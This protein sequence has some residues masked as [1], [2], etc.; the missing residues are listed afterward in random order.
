LIAV[1]G[2]SDGHRAP[3]VSVIIVTF[4]SVS[5]I[6]ACLASLEASSDVRLEVIVVDNAS[7]DETTAV[8][9]ACGPRVIVVEAGANLGFAQACN[10]GAT[11]ATAPLL[12]FLNPDTVVE[13]EAIAAAAEALW[14]DPS[15]GVVGAMTLYENGSLNPTCCF[16]QP[17]LTGTALRAIGLSTVRKGSSRLNPEEM[18]GWDRST[19]RDVGVVTGCFFLIERELFRHLRGF[20]ERFFMYSE[21]TDLSLRVQQVG[22]RCVHLATARVIHH[23]GRSDTVAAHKM[24]KTFR[25]RADF[26][27]KHWHPGKAVVGIALLDLTALSRSLASRALGRRTKWND[28]WR[29]REEWHRRSDPA[30]SDRAAR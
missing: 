21:D 17:T 13:R 19:T 1:S 10:L 8:V 28:V 2:R 14:T 7:E 6:G 11:R 27:R 18:G 12:L 9:V 5:T 29:A 15:V 26:F 4:N 30:A 20:D 22:L 3:D 24:I 25:A 23:G 16:A